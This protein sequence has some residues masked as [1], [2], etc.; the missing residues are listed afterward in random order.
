VTHGVA[1]RHGV[2]LRLGV[3]RDPAL[4]E[5]ANRAATNVL[6]VRKGSHDQCKSDYPWNPLATRPVSGCQVE[7][8]QEDVPESGSG[9]QG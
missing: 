1:S 6:S 4:F 5:T 2:A 7:T 9:R 3:P 8:L